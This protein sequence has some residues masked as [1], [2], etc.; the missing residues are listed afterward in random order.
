[1][2]YAYGPHCRKHTLYYSALGSHGSGHSS[3][4]A[5]GRIAHHAC[6]RDIYMA[7]AW[8][9]IY[10]LYAKR[11]NANNG[12]SIAGFFL[13]SFVYLN[14]LSERFRYGDY[15]YYS[16]CRRMFAETQTASR[17]P[18]Y[19]RHFGQRSCNSSCRSATKIF[20]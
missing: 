17:A 9:L 4:L 19:I 13:I 10:L 18:I 12:W 16:R 14:Q 3:R 2:E 11:V 5:A 8:T 6:I 15:S 1:M 7:I 20:Y